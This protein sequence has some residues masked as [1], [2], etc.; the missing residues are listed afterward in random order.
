MKKKKATTGLVC[1]CALAMLAVPVYGEENLQGYGQAYAQIMQNYENVFQEQRTT[2]GVAGDVSGINAEF[3]GAAASS[4]Q[5]G[6]QHALFLLHDLNGDSTP[7]LFIG[8]GDTEMLENC[9]IYDVYTFQGGNAVRLMEG[10]GYRAGSCVICQDGIIKD[11]SSGSAFDSMIQYHRL[12]ENGTALE[13]VESISI[14]GENPDGTIKYFH[15]FEGNEANAISQT[16]YQA[17]EAQYQQVKNMHVW[18]ITQDNIGLM[19]QEK[20]PFETPEEQKRE[21]YRAYGKVVE[22][23]EAKYGPM[24]TNVPGDVS[25]GMTGLCYLDLLDFNQDG[26]DELF[27]VYGWSEPKEDYSIKNYSAEIW[28]LNGQEA[29]KV[30]NTSLFSVNGGVQNVIFTRF[31][32]KLY[33]V[34]GSG[35]SFCYRDYYT[36]GTDGISMVRSSRLDEPGDAANCTIDGQQVSYEEWEVQEGQWMDSSYTYTLYDDADGAIQRKIDGVKEAIG[37]SAQAA[38][39]NTQDQSGAQPGDYILAES[40]GELLSEERIAGL[41]SNDIQMAI[42]E[43]YARHGRKF[44]T[45]EIQEYFNGKSWYQ[46]TIEPDSFDENLLSEIERQ[47]VDFLAAHLQ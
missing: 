24:Q 12:P 38:E 47:N 15:D 23:C 3:L 46:G 29:F 17:I 21:D 44:S 40:S 36:Y 2:G 42:N 11:Q 8:L 6:Q 43:I 39:N 33:Q 1:V 9:G 16:D 30:G 32:G 20:I 45:P 37:V 25:L 26:T 27:M 35:D 18:M 13:T 14:H 22:E 31:Q 28:S 5:N 7:E 34:G 10:I 41:S 4:T 19:Q